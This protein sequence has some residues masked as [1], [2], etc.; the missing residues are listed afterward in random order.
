MHLTLLLLL[1]LSYC[2]SHFVCTYHSVPTAFPEGLQG[3]GVIPSPLCK[4]GALLASCLQLPSRP[5][6]ASCPAHCDWCEMFVFWGACTARGNLPPAASSGWFSRGGHAPTGTLI[7]GLPAHFYVVFCPTLAATQR[8]CDMFKTCWHCKL[9]TG[10]WWSI[11]YDCSLWDFMAGE[12]ICL[13]LRCLMEAA[14]MICEGSAIFPKSQN[15]I[16]PW[17]GVLGCS[18]YINPQLPCFKVNRVFHAS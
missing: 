1:P 11:F 4:D 8:D 12:T 6:A 17:Q 16:Q 7:P 15:K 3:V 14:A 10:K 9:L 13:L 2:C 5:V 18:L